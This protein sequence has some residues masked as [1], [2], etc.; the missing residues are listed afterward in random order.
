MSFRRSIAATLSAAAMLVAAAGPAEP[1]PIE[2]N[3]EEPATLSTQAGGR[4][5]SRA[6]SRRWSKPLEEIRLKHTPPEGLLPP[7]RS[8]GLFTPPEGSANTRAGRHTQAVFHW[9][10]SNV[11]CQPSYFDDVPLERYGQTVYPPLQPVLSG[12]HFFGMF[13]IMP[14]KIGIDRT[15]DPVYTLGYYRVGTA[16]P[17]VRQR[18]PAEIDASLFEAL[19]WT[20]LIFALP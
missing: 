4:D 12:V 1:A 10:P 20:A 16:A 11:E 15:H 5:A 2:P 9:V 14:Y 8:G 13:P 19:V 3:A 18:L 17:P 7:D 6:D